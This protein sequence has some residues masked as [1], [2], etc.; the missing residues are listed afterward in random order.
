MEI[1]LTYGHHAEIDFSDQ[2]K[3]H[4]YVWRASIHNH[5]IYAVTSIGGSTVAMHSLIKPPP[6][7]FIID[8]RDS[9]GL[10]NR[11]NNLR[12]VTYKQNAQHRNSKQWSENA[13]GY[14]GVMLL[15][16]GNYQARIRHDGKI[17][18]LG[19]YPSAEEAARVYDEAAK[20]WHGEYAILNFGDLK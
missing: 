13:S 17:V 7:G 3:I 19:A 16:S 10:N 4:G 6:D 8:H 15:Y 11:W 14:R 20:K 5:I 2:W 9:N 18:S 1:E 12:H